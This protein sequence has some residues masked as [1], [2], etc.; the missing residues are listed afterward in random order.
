MTTEK[1]NKKRILTS[2]E[3]LSDELRELFA[4]TYPLGY[5]N[6]VLPLTK[7]NGELIYVVRLETEEVS[8]L[9]KVEVKID[10]VGD[11][12]EEENDNYDA[13]NE[14]LEA[15]DQFAD[16]KEEDDSYGDD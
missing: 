8:Y 16:D 12:E 10:D 5:Y 2:Y 1:D 14:R 4:Q 11:L 13:E 15:A 3:R 7:P 6:A 9:V